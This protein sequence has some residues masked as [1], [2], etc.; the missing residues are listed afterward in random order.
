MYQLVSAI[1]YS[2][3]IKLIHRDLKPQNILIKKDE[4]GFYRVK[5]CDFGTCQAFKIGDIQNKVVGSAF[6]IAPEVFQ[7]KYN[8]KCDMCSCGVIMVVLLTKKLPFGGKN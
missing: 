8:Y 4:E 7:K 1:H 3:N 6:Y 2:H 5:I